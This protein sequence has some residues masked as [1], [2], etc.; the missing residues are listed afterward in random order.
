MQLRAR[1]AAVAELVKQ[2]PSYA[3]AQASKAEAGPP[4]PAEPSGTNTRHL[5][6][7]DSTVQGKGA[8]NPPQP[9]E[10]VQTAG[11][12]ADQKPLQSVLAGIIDDDEMEDLFGPGTGSSTNTATSPAFAMA[13]TGSTGGT[14]A[15]GVSDPSAGQQDLASMLAGQPPVAGNSLG[16]DLLAGPQAQQSGFASGADMPGFPGAGAPSGQMDLSTLSG[17]DFNALLAGL[18]TGSGDDPLAGFTLGRWTA[19]PPQNH[20]DCDS[21]GVYTDNFDLSSIL[22]GTDQG[23]QQ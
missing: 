12:P 4:A 10:A 11:P 6:M 23:M 5:E 16:I 13:K 7:S 21:L 22:G 19:F 1:A 15:A 9:T 14:A 3:P 17:D 20:D 18:G 8:S 2:D